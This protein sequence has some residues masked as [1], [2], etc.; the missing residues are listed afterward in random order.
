MR[1]SLI[2]VAFA[3]ITSSCIGTDFSDSLDGSWQLEAGTLEGEAITTIES[4]PVTMTL[5]NGEISGTAACNGFGGEYEVSG[6]TFSISGGLAVTEMACHPPAVMES[7]RMF[8]L[9]LTTVD[10]VLLTNMGLLLRGADTELGF[11]AIEPAPAS[12]LTGTV[13]VLEGLGDGEAVSSM[14][15]GSDRATLE[16]FTDGSFIGSTGC[17]T[18]SGTY[19]VTG[20]EVQFTNFRADGDC[21]DDLSAQDRHVISAL[22]GGIRVEIEGDRMTT[23]ASRDEGLVYRADG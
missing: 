21:E 1:T 9:A 15:A 2:L 18:I 5:G 7:E 19:L 11:S 23:S 8:L 4:H 10:E 13:W 14:A 3:L 6:S 17:R 16:L 12:E 20:A 22:E